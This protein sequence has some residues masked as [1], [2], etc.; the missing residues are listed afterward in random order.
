MNPII[1]KMKHLATGQER[2]VIL[3]D[4]DAATKTFLVQDSDDNIFFAQSDM[5]KFKSMM[6]MVT[7]GRIH[8]L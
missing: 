7:Q 3:L 5:Y 8:K 4:A 1:V 6:K 2:E